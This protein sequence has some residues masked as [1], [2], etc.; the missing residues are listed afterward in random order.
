LLIGAGRAHPIFAT[1]KAVGRAARVGVIVA[2]H[3]TA[4]GEGVLAELASLLILP[5]FPQ[6]V[7]ELEVDLAASG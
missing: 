2:Q 4:A 6:G 3:P 1:G 7:V 5:R